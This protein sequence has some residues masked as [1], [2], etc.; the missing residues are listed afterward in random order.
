[1]IMTSSQQHVPPRFRLKQL[2]SLQ[3]FEITVQ[4]LQ[5][6]FAHGQITSVD[7]V[8][9]C[10]ERIETVNPY[11]EA[12]IELNPDAVILA[13]SLDDERKQG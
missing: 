12:I 7:Y 3:V 4:Q 5:S 13:A 2:G 10:I 8:K 6:Y 1:M 11:L 9:Y